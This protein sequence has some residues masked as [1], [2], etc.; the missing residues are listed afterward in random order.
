MTKKIED[1]ELNYW[2]GPEGPARVERMRKLWAKG[3]SCSQ[4]ATRMGDDVTKSMVIGK[5]TRLGAKAR[6]EG[7]T[8]YVAATGHP[9]PGYGGRTLAPTAPPKPPKPEVMVRKP[10]ETPADALLAASTIVPFNATWRLGDQPPKR[11]KWPMGDPLKDSFCVCGHPVG[12]P[13]DPK[14]NYC[15]KHLAVATHPGSKQ[16]PKA[17][18]HGLRRFL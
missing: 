10:R 8:A 9:P 16:T 14:A 12:E 17:R 13:D 7:H 15:D 3:L 11:C 6:S 18:L 1:R 5:I 4:V 2:E